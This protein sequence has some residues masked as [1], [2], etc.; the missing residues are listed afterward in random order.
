MM[1]THS[2]T[3]EL[4]REPTD[5]EFD[6]LADTCSDAAFGTEQRRP[7]AQFDRAATSLPRA[8]ATAVCDLAL[9]NLDVHSVQSEDLLFWPDALD[10]IGL[11]E[12][13]LAER[14]GQSAAAHPKP[15]ADHGPAGFHS[16]A[17][18]REWLA[19]HGIGQDYDLAIRAAD[20]VVS[21][22]GRAADLGPQQLQRQI[23]A[24]MEHLRQWDARWQ[25]S[26][27]MQPYLSFIANTGGPH[28]T[29]VEQV[30]GMVFRLHTEKH[31]AKTNVVFWT[32]AFG[33]E[34]QVHLLQR[35]HHAGALGQPLQ[36]GGW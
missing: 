29:T 18:I 16:W 12:S 13:T 3:L 8:I 14:V 2:F 26:E 36:G 9:T 28:P 34:Q 35:L 20:E 19:A 17:E 4:D 22:V 33:V 32:L 1:A 24:R 10:R 6:V 5:E 27:W 30:E 15:M 25:M 31:L 23:E 21:G 11:P 7:R